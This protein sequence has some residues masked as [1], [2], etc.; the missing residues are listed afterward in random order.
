MLQ[1]L[2]RDRLGAAKKKSMHSAFSPQHLNRR[3]AAIQGVVNDALVSMLAAAPRPSC[4]VLQGKL[5]STLSSHGGPDPNVASVLCTKGNRATYYTV[6]YALTVGPAYS[7][8]WIGVFGP[9]AHRNEYRLLATAVD[10]LHNKT[11]ALANL[12]RNLYGQMRFLAYGINWGDPHN[13]LIVIVYTFN[14]HQIKRTW[15]RT[16]L[17][18]GKVTVRKH[19][20]VLSFLNMAVGPGFSGVRTVTKVYRVTPCGVEIESTSKGPSS[21]GVK[22]PSHRR[23]S[24]AR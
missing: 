8:S 21:N 1:D 16:G 18:Q 3:L 22:P 12:P 19:R 17:P 7:R 11:V 4:K 14:G 24:G 5:R 2:S 6:A 15:S 9:S 23:P 13:R 20:I 10:T